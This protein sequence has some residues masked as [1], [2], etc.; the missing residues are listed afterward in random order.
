MSRNKVNKRKEYLD[1]VYGIA[2]ISIGLLLALF[3]FSNATGFI[4]AY[5]TKILRVLIGV[6]RFLVPLDRK[7][8]V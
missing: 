5:T 8:V 3:I 7:S 4:G 2:L 6:G 1:E